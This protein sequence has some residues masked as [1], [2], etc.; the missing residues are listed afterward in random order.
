M[1]KGHLGGLTRDETEYL[2]ILMP[3]PSIGP[4]WFRTI[5]ID[6]DGYKLFWLGPNYFGQVQIILIRFKLDFYDI[7]F[8]IWTQPKQSWPNLNKLD[9]S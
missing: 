4:K 7:V 9:P 8:T 2:S 5:Q 6:L 3:C 1:K